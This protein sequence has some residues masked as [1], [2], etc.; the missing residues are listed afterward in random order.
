MAAAVL[1]VGTLG[2]A[3]HTVS[4]LALE[5]APYSSAED[6]LIDQIAEDLKPFASGISLQQVERSFCA[7]G[8]GSDGGFRYTAVLC[9]PL[10]LACAS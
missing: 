7:G 3:S 5:K 10:A 4:N 9:E 1:I 2:V 6:R 8:D